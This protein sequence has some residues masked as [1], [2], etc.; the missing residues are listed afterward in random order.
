VD[1]RLDA[2]TSVFAITAAASTVSLDAN[3]RGAASFTV[4]N[5][6]ANA[7][8]GRARIVA[9]AAAA[10]PWL[11]LAGDAE[12]DFAP[13]ATQQ[14]TAQIAVPAD[15][16]AGN[17]AFRLDA[18]G[19]ANPDEQY[20]QGPSVAFSVA[21]PPPPP[22]PSK[23]FPWLL[24]IIG[25]VVVLAIVGGVVAFLLLRNVTVP[26]VVG[27]PL[28]DAQGTLVAASLHVGATAETPA[29]TTP[30]TVL[31]QVP[32]GG[33][34]AP[35]NSGVDLVLAVPLPT[36]TPTSTP[37]PTAT[38]T[39]PPPPLVSSAVVG[40]AQVTPGGSAAARVGCPAGTTVVSGGVDLSQVLTEKVT[41]SAPTFGGNI[42]LISQPDGTGPAPTGWQASAVNND[43]GA[44]SFKVAVMCGAAAG[45]ASRS[46]V[47]GSSTVTANS[48][49]SVRVTCPGGTV[50]VGGGVDVA[51]IG[52]MIVTASAPTFVANNNRLIFQPDGAAAAPNGWQVSVLN[53][54]PAAQT[55]KG[56]AV[57]AAFS[58]LTA[59]VGSGNASA[60]TFSTTRVTCPGGR[61]AS[62]GGIDLE[63][64]FTMKVTSSGP[65]FAVNNSRLI[66]QP[67]GAAPAPN[68]WQASGLNNDTTAKPFKVAAI[69]AP[70]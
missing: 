22:P 70:T 24:V 55:I 37:S 39:P 32:G 9:Q 63:N 5:T 61:V 23:P 10:A 67:D 38:A 20:S 59:V 41:S 14:Y 26:N 60:G 11:S 64:V 62:G 29:A 65:T 21:A 49:G 53:S 51:N 8:R 48:F 68:G 25:V 16:P 58:S 17:Y 18:V 45:G 12:R 13:G 56:A 2:A 50:A 46:T 40:S 34:P 43:A 44:Q 54:G 69:C 30:S 31:Q 28:A 57:C 1:E 19:V 66:F 42:R 35:R 15:G 52:N 3:R 33:T 4:T 6:T 7:L 47:V 36:S 27:E